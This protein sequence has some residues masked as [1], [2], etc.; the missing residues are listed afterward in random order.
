MDPIVDRGN[1][2]GATSRTPPA[3]V[4]SPTLQTLVRSTHDRW[5]LD[6]LDATAPTDLRLARPTVIVEVAGAR[7]GLDALS[8]VRRI[9]HDEPVAAIRLAPSESIS[10]LT[11]PQPGSRVAWLVVVLGALAGVVVTALTGRE[12]FH[13]G[14]SGTAMFGAAVAASLVGSV[15]AVRWWRR[16]RREPAARR[17]HFEQRRCIAVIAVSS[18]DA[19]SASH[20][21]STVRRVLDDA[22]PTDRYD[23]TVF[24]P[25]V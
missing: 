4:V 25:P 16:E 3:G 2:R 11:R 7:A 14:S 19:G 23:V 12:A 6:T 10:E 24:E 22:A 15:A 8:R 13:R 20:L 17:H 18:A 21:A 1:T 5:S 9:A